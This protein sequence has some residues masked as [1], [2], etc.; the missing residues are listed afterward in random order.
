[1]LCIDKQNLILASSSIQHRR[2]S[3]STSQERWK[4]QGR[5]ENGFCSRFYCK[6]NETK[7]AETICLELTIYK[8]KVVDSF[9]LPSP[10]T[11]KEEFF[12]EI[13]VSLNR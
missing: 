4:L 13:P 2:V 10:N 9:C 12:D 8:K 3:V 1:M 6:A 7:N 5:S 11:D